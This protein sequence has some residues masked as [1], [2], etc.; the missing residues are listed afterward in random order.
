MVYVR[1]C[2]NSLPNDVDKI[3]DMSKLNAFADDTVT[4]TQKLELV[5]EIVKNILG[6]R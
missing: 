2:G 4:V 1:D 6:K 5:L 3:L